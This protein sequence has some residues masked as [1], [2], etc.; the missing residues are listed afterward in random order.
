MPHNEV[1]KQAQ[2]SIVGFELETLQFIHNTLTQRVILPGNTPTPTKASLLTLWMEWVTSCAALFFN[3]FPIIF[4]FETAWSLSLFSVKVKWYTRQV[5]GIVCVFFGVFFDVA[6]PLTASFVSLNSVTLTFLVKE[7]CNIVKDD[8][9][10]IIAVICSQQLKYWQ[11]MLFL[12]D[13]FFVCLW[14]PLLVLCLMVQIYKIWN[15]LHLSWIDMNLKLTLKLTMIWMG[16]RLILQLSSLIDFLMFCLHLLAVCS[17]FQK[18]K[19]HCNLG[20]K[21]TYSAYWFSLKLSVKQNN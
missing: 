16:G 4:L 21:S 20:C 15:D 7:K 9:S 11:Q 18:A 19:G 13:S 2:P 14:K 10:P 8:S 12:F 3:S 5:L 17:C 6:L 1:S